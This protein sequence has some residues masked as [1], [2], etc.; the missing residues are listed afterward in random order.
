ML[1][2]LTSGDNN[3]ACSGGFW[4]LLINKYICSDNEDEAWLHMFVVMV[5]VRKPDYCIYIFTVTVM[6]MKPDCI[7]I[8]MIQTSEVKF[9]NAVTAGGSVKFMPAV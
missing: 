1:L 7:Y 6:V 5:I 8:R 2:V 4:W 3:E 9:V